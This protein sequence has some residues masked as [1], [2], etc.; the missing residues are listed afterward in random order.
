VQILVGATPDQTVI[1][2]DGQALQLVKRCRFTCDL[3]P[4]TGEVTQHLE[5]ELYHREDQTIPVPLVDRIQE[6]AYRVPGFELDFKLVDWPSA[7]R[8]AQ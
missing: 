2:V 7:A 4:E 8:Q 6:M 5:L 3:D 1:T